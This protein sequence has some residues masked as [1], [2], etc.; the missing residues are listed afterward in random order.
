MPA[1]I[2]FALVTDAEHPDLDDDSRLLVP[3]LRAAGHSVETPRWNDRDVDW[4]RYRLALIRSTWDYQHHHDDYVAWARHVDSVSRLQNSSEV[5]AWNTDK[6]YLDDLERRG[7]RVVPTI[8]LERGCG[9]LDL[10]AARDRLGTRELVVKPAV[11]STGFE[12]F[13]LLPGDEAG[14]ERLRV[15]IEQRDVMIQPFLKRI[16]TEGERSLLF[17]DGQLLHCVSKIAAAGEFRVHE[18]HGGTFKQV[19]PAADDLEFA[20]GVLSVLPFPV[21]Y[22]RVDVVTD[23]DGHPCVCELEVTEPSFYLLQAPASV[24]PMVEALRRRL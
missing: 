17:V 13:R 10:V 22:A 1:T 12:T 20:R 8:W 14:E 3:P 18:E 4:S 5:V 21:M 7:T 15:L 2:D 24:A 16:L 9:F 19:E 11:S 23:N 6:R